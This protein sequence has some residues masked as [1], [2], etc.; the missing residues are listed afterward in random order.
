MDTDITMGM[1]TTKYRDTLD[2]VIMGLLDMDWLVETMGAMEFQVMYNTE[3][4]L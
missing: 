4:Q 1:D 3:A 2:M